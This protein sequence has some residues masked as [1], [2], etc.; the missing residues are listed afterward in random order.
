MRDIHDSPSWLKAFSESGDARAIQLQL[1]TDGVNPFSS[2][3]VSYSMWPIMLSNLNLPR[4]VRSYFGNIMLVGV[5]PA[6]DGGGEPRKLDP[7][8]EIVVD[9]LLSL[10]GK[11][12]YDAYKRESFEFKCSLLNFVLDYPGCA[13]IFN[14]AGPTAL[15][16][17]MWCDLRGKLYYIIIT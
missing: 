13:K 7:Y 2:N 15:Q 8:L 6:Q 5:I 9:E 3:K 4:S 11:T 16:A 12:F 14:A 10:T 17:C 1:S